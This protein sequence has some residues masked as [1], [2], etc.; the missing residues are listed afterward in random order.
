MNKP[1]D[2][3]NFYAREIATAINFAK[4]SD[5]TK[6]NLFS[7][8]EVGLSLM[9]DAVLHRVTREEQRSKDV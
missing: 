7:D 8:T 3:F 9:L 1:L 6:E 5:K 2:H 4:V